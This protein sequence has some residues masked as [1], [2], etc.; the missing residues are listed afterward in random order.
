MAKPE[1]SKRLKDVWEI[2]FTLIDRR[3]GDHPIKIKGQLLSEFEMITWPDLKK[4]I[5]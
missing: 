4:K 3:T 5:K 2:E 1:K